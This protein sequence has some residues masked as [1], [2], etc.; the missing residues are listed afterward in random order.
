MQTLLVSKGHPVAG[1]CR[2]TPGLLLTARL[3]NHSQRCHPFGGNATSS[4]AAPFQWLLAPTA[5]S[6]YCPQ[7]PSLPIILQP[8][9]PLSYT[10][11]AASASSNPFSSWKSQSFNV[12]VLIPISGF[13]CSQKPIQSLPL[14]MG[15]FL[16][17]LSGFPTKILPQFTVLWTLDI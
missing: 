6:P 10:A 13:Y 7:A 15:Q 4:V 16:P 2:A 14:G 17:W 9:V 5:A 11:V 12:T 1:N 8:L 3:G